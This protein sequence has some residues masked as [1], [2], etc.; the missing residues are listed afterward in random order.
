[1]C[2]IKQVTF[3]CGH[4]YNLGTDFCEGKGNP[5]VKCNSRY[6]HTKREKLCPKCQKEEEEKVAKNTCGRHGGHSHGGAKKTA[7]KTK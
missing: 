6:V 3:A 4:K 2:I 5:A 7:G 1:M